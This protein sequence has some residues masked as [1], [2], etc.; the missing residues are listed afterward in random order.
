[1]TYE[2]SESPP[3]A[4]A[5]V[6]AEQRVELDVRPVLRGGEDPFELIMDALDDVPHG[7]VLRLRAP[8]KPVPLLGVMASKGWSHWI[9][10]G[11]GDDWVIWFYR[12]EDFP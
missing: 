5:G 4:L 3:D 10:H 2:G 8:F 6:T 7:H 12:D 1:M 9:E 11:E